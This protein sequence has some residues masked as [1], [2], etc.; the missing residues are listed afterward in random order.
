MTT[1][2]Q[3]YTLNVPANTFAWGT[4]CIGGLGLANARGDFHA[5]AVR[6]VR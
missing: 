2:F 6:C 3:T 4:P 5:L 1:S